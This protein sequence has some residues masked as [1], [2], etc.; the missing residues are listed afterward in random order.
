[1]VWTMEQR[2]WRIGEL[3]DAAGVTVRALRH[4][5]RLGLLVPSTRTSGGHRVYSGADVRRLYRLLALR[6]LGVRLDDVAPLLDGGDLA[7]VARAQLERVDDDIERLNGLRARL[8]RLLELIAAD[9][10]APASHYLD[11]MEAMATMDRYYTPEQLA[12]LESRRRELGPEGM[13]S[14]QRD[15]AELIDEARGHMERDPADPAVQAIVARWDSLIEHFTG[16]DPG[17]RDSLQKLYDDQGP[18]A[19]SRGSVDPDLM[20]YVGR[21]RRLRPRR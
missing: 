6:S 15:W 18:T 9:G 4:Y 14:A 16:G 7:A 13:E 17:I 5:D 3:A 1:M 21:A 8:H 11:A 19:A 10:D 20:A 12:Q 2:D